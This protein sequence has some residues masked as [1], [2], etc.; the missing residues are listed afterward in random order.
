MGEVF[1]GKIVLVVYSDTMELGANI[2]TK[3]G[4]THTIIDKKHLSSSGPITT[5]SWKY[6]IPFI[7]DSDFAV[8][9]LEFSKLLRDRQE[10]ISE[11]KQNNDYNIR[12]EF[13]MQSEI[14]QV[15]YML[16]VKTMNNLAGLGLHCDFKITLIGEG[17]FGQLLST[18]LPSG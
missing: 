11:L 3:L 5:N 2:D 16:D 4:L 8:K 14:E 15:G 1:R 6:E 18:I 13:N 7:G 17:E 12:V 9:V 10:N